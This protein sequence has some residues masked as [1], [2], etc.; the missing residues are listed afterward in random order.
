MASD[1][2]IFEYF[3]AN[4]FVSVAMATYQIQQFGQN[5]YVS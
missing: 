2:I 4:F 5:L 3:L 1:E